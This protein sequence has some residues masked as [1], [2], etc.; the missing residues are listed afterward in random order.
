MTTS[1]Y[2]RTMPAA[3]A[4][5]DVTTAPVERYQRVGDWARDQS[6]KLEMQAL[7]DMAF[8]SVERAVALA[9]EDL[10]GR[11]VNLYP[12]GRVRFVCPWAKH[13]KLWPLSLAQREL[14]RALLFAATRQHGKGSA[15]APLFFFDGERRRWV[16]NVG[17]YPT[18]G[19][20]MTWLRWARSAWTPE[21]VVAA[22]QWLETRTPDGRKRGVQVGATSGSGRALG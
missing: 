13:S 5:T 3:S 11:R 6:R 8:A 1:P 18:A 17:D 12:D 9:Y 2:R 14:V 19:E 21:T 4:A 16:C 10:G 7:A 15:P 22:L 20:A